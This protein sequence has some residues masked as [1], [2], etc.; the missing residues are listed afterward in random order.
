MKETTKPM[1]RTIQ[2]LAVM[3]T[4]A[5]SRR[6]E[7]LFFQVPDG[8][9]DHGGNGEQELNSRAEGRSRPANWP[10]AMVDMER[11]VPGKTAERSDRGRSRWPAGGSSAQRGCGGLAALDQA[12]TIHMAMRQQE[13]NGDDIE[14]AQFFSLHLWRRRAGRR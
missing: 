14:A 13:G 9:G 5:T 3:T 4:W 2:L 12:S 7:D 1:T 8:G 10:A 11:E 6:G